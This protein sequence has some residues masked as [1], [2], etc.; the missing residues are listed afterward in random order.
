[1]YYDFSIDWLFSL[2]K[3][4]SCRAGA[5]VQHCTTMCVL[6]VQLNL[7]TSNL[8]ALL[9]FMNVLLNFFP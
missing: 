4:V 2:Q 8:N 5:L 3:C 9:L 1:M 6:K 7:L